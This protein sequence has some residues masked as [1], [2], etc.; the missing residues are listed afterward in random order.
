MAECTKYLGAWLDKDLNFRKHIAVKCKA[1]TLNLLRIKMIANGLDSNT[2]KTLVVSLVLSH[3][4]YANCILNNTPK[5]DI[6][7]LQQI[8][9]MA[10]K[11]I[12]GKSK[13][14]SNT[15]CLK[16]LHWLPVKNRIQFKTLCIVYKCLN[17]KGPTY[18]KELLIEENSTKHNLRSCKIYKQLAV[19]RTKRKTFA[20]HAFSV[21]G[22]KLWNSLPNTAKM[23]DNYELFKQKLKSYLF[24]Q[25]FNC[26]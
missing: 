5:K 3:L 13:Y 14:D 22:P 2:L 18:L 7:L 12:C 9:N 8:Q 15:E 25:A 23:A 26:N 19:P 17:G 4:D 10:A 16:T 20:D 1:A 6:K 24:S 21:A 11:L